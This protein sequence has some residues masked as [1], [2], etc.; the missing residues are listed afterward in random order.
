MIVQLDGE[1]DLVRDAGYPMEAM[2]LCGTRAWRITGPAGTARPE[3]APGGHRG[4]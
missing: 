4:T 3:T 1:V 2:Q